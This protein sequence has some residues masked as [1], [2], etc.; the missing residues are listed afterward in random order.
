MLFIITQIVTVQPST[1]P[2]R[3]NSPV[4]NHVVFPKNSKCQTARNFDKTTKPPRPCTSFIHP[5]SNYSWYQLKNAHTTSS[6][7][8]KA[9]IPIF[10]AVA[11]LIT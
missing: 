1:F 5:L 10:V 6:C 7:H 11:T 8:N 4:Q 2:T 9:K 3:Q